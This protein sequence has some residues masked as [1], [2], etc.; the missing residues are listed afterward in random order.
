MSLSLPY[1]IIKDLLEHYPDYHHLV[2]STQLV[3]AMFGMGV[4]TRPQAFVEIVLEPK[5]MIAGLL[6]QLIGIP[7]ITAAM[8]FFVELPPEVVVGLFIVAAMPGGSMSNIYTYIGKGNAA[9][10]VALTGV[11]TLLA[12]VTA[13]LILRIFAAEHL[14]PLIAMP[15]SSIMREIFVFL[16]LPLTVGMAMGHFVE[17]KMALKCSK[18]TLRASLVVLGILVVGSL[19][20]GRIDFSTYG[21]RIP[22]I[23]FLYCLIIQIIILRGSLHVL[24]FSYRDST[25][26]GIESSMKNINLGVLIA[27]SLFGIEGENAAFGAGVLFVLLLYGGVNLFVA[28]VPAISNIRYLKK[29]EKATATER[30]GTDAGQQK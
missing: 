15:V 1:R 8:V 18:W 19:G 6:Y 13:P 29:V 5:P 14:P 11:M 22:F 16:L 30:A 2:A 26:L 27:A 28:A 10:S 3:L 20:S 12:I 23:V 17:V 7:L 21:P 9:L 4:V 25:A 24:K